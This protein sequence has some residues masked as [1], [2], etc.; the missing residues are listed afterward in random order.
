M[1][2]RGKANRKRM[3]KV[4]SEI[5][6]KREKQLLL[7]TLRCKLQRSKKTSERMQSEL[8]SFKYVD[9]NIMKTMEEI[10]DAADNNDVHAS[11]IMDQVRSSDA[12][13]PKN[14]YKDCNNPINKIFLL[15]YIITASSMG[16]G[17]VK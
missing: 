3:E 10:K 17:G 6:A 15:R 7:K 5:K 8:D 13:F 11:F 4:A 14:S 1:R 12:L 9:K 16:H 2:T